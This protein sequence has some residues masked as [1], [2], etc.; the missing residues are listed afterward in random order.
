[1]D[2]GTQSYRAR[3][4][5]EIAERRARVSEMYLTGRKTH[6]QI[7]K[8]LGVSEPVVQEDLQSLQ[9]QWRH[10][11]RLNTDA[12]IAIMLKKLDADEKR[13]LDAFE[14]SRKPKRIASA[15]EK[16]SLEGTE[17]TRSASVEERDEG[18]VRFLAELHKCR[19]LR[20]KILG[21]V[22]KK[23]DDK[24]EKNKLNGTYADYVAALLKEREQNRNGA[25]S[26]ANRPAPIP[27]NPKRLP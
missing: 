25:T 19:E 15:S 7:A 5:V 16:H 8:E 4:R 17:T 2:V 26:K 10:D 9:A 18:D 24:E 27:L 21:L 3:K 6:L 22:G 11:A 14:R 20:C 23:D 12:H 1:M 13:A